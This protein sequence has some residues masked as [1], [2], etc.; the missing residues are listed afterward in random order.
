M[1]LTFSSLQKRLLVLLVVPVALFLAGAGVSGYYYMWNA[2]VKEWQKIAMLKMERAAHQMDM[3]LE[4]PRRW[5]EDFTKADSDVTRGWILKQLRH[6]PGVSRVEVTWGKLGPNRRETVRQETAAPPGITGISPVTYIYTP[7][8]DSFVL[9]GDFLGEAGQ[10]LGHV[11]VRIAY[12]YLMKKILTTGWMQT[13]MACL[14]SDSG[15]YLAHS[16]PSMDKRHCLGE[17]GN[18][19]ELA[20]LQEMK[21]KSS[22]TIVGQGF[23]PN[24][25]VGFY[26]L[27]NAPWAIMLH[28][29]G[30]QILAPILRFR[31][32]Y[33]VG[34][35]LCLLVILLLLR[36]GTAPLIS[37]IRQISQKAAQV[38][39]GEYGEPLPVESRDEI[40]R[41]AGSFER[42]RRR[43]KAR[44]DERIAQLQAERSDAQGDCEKVQARLEDLGLRRRQAIAWALRLCFSAST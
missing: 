17:T 34:G 24:Q 40:G 2:L 35:I 36:L 16:N 31:L 38:A 11:E 9:Q 33:L 12:S 18:L 32:Y 6:L 28:A 43:L 27:N 8:K 21:K 20:M 29:R 30:S 25:V 15:K 5:M 3:R 10:V 26:K 1:L 4:Q 41:L 14:V 39:Q 13:Q 23:T 7:G 42:M 44:L 22:A 37:A 19:L